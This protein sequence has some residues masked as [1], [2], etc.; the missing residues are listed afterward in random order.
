[1]F[2][3]LLRIK[4]VVLSSYVLQVCK[5]L[6]I[7]KFMEK[8]LQ[9]SVLCGGQSTEHEISVLSAKNVVA[10]LNRDKYDITV[11]YIT[12]QGQWYLIESPKLFLENDPKILL[13]S[14]Q[15]DPVTV[16]LGDSDRPWQSLNNSK[17]RYP[18]ECVFPVLHG[19]FGE[20]GVPQ[21]LMELLG[22]PYV[23][24]DAQ[25]SAM[26]MEKDITKQLLRSA[27]VPNVDWVTVRH[28][29]SLSGLY[30]K[31]ADQFG[32]VLFVK[33][34]S[35]GSSVGTAPVS[36]QIA[37][38][39]AVKEALRYDERVIVEPHIDGR[40]IE[41]SVLGNDNPEASL[42]G[43]IISH[44][45]YYSYDAK[46]IDPKGAST[47]APA[48]LPSDLIARIRQT[49]VN[50]FKVMHCS[51]MARVDFFVVD[52]KDIYVNELNTIPGFTNIS[53]YPTMWEVSGLSYSDLLDKLI[54]L[55]MERHRFQQSLIRI[56]HQ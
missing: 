24:A 5:T 9:L 22:L 4:K 10:A 56:Y 21:G 52:D 38:E 16:V 7:I 17:E 8:K 14:G 3:H 53:M 41:C 43:E 32:K 26:C 35:L 33:P 19:T 27:G 44:H 40:E 28:T 36:D 15:L 18:A 51:G 42:P 34:T 23:G 25:S 12:H 20:D 50:A 47:E 49:A 45:N 48:K 30:Q 1:M 54:E 11:I 2:P 6:P 37:F 13:Q 55:A 39:S 46:Y 29:D 31:L